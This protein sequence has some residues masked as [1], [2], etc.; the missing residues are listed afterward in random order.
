MK[1]LAAYMFQT[2]TLRNVCF[3]RKSK[4][5][6]FTRLRLLHY[7]RNYGM[8]GGLPQKSRMFRITHFA[9]YMFRTLTVRNVCLTR[10]SRISL[11]SR[12][13]LLHYRRLTV[14]R[15]RLPQKSRM[16]RIKHPAT[17][18]FRTP[19]VRNVRLTRKSKISRLTWLRLLHY[20]K[21]YGMLCESSV[22]IKDVQHK[23]PCCLHVPN[24]YGTECA[25]YKN[26]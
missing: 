20:P 13:R 3:T 17:Y 2:V 14:C 15:V 11:F 22:E 6:S 8:S 7:P 1:H 23:A 25:S 9:A 24:F 12:L 16:S 18:M 10:K 26:V 4:I 5:S 19:T 21:T